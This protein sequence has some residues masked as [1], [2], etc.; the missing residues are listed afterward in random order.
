MKYNWDFLKKKKYIAVLLVEF[1]LLLLGIISLFTG[2]KT[3]YSLKESGVL[4]NLGQGTKT[5]EYH[6]GE[7]SNLSG[8]FFE[9]G[10]ITLIPGVYDI[11]ITYETTGAGEGHSFGIKSETASFHAFLTN[12]GMLDGGN[13]QAVTRLWLKETITDGKLYVSYAGSGG[14]T[15]NNVEIVGTSAGSRIFL[16]W[17]LLGSLAVDL[18]IILYEKNKRNEL[19][20]EKRAVYMAIPIIT[21]IASLPLL[22]DYLIVGEALEYHLLRIENLSLWLS[23]HGGLNS[24][25]ECGTFMVLPALLRLMGFTVNA[26]YK[27]YIVAV[28]LATALTAYY[29]FGKWTGSKY[30]GLLGSL[31]YTLAPYRIYLLYQEAA[32]PQYTAMIFVP[33]ACYGVSRLLKEESREHDNSCSPVLPIIGFSGLI[34][35]D[36]ITAAIVGIALSI[37][38]LLRIKSIFRQKKVLSL[39]GV[40]V[41]VVLINAWFLVPYA[42]S[43]SFAGYGLTGTSED[44]IQGRGLYL[45]HFFYTLQKQGK[46]LEFDAFGM[47]GS[48]PA[49][50]GA[51]LL[52]GIGIYLGLGVS[53]KGA[54]GKDSISTE[55]RRTVFI[56]FLFG[57]AALF[58]STRYFPWNRLQNLHPVLNGL[59]A[60]MKTPARLLLIAV[61]SITFLTC[62]MVKWMKR[63]KGEGWGKAAFFGIAGIGLVFAL[64]QVNN[65]LLEGRQIVR[66]YSAAGISGANMIKGAFSPAV[67]TGGYHMAA[68]AVSMVTVLGLMLRYGYLKRKK[69]R[70]VL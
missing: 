3:A 2:N 14:L 28:N 58:L 41:W 27:M 69:G 5:E 43:L 34:Q 49:I 25:S 51:A 19:P 68:W 10:D 9:S 21:L 46:T 65:A 29:G 59:I 20:A 47:M 15:V 57:L 33:A 40:V 61:V 36:M 16:F 38:C 66:L 62:F 56:A 4:T 55:E 7:D 45:A 50:L 48:A 60:G 35:S 53:G 17:T 12:E 8:I 6:I 24:L 23:G 70:A 22:N 32:V 52:A 64:F 37:L 30:I 42:D 11:K 67:N 44:W 13:I 31:L 18:L 39:S 1:L 54:S 63:I 26:S